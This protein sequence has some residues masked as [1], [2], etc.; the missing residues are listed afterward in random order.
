ML[1]AI[2]A[3]ERIRREMK[4]NERA[5]RRA[6]VDSIVATLHDEFNAQKPSLQALSLKGDYGV[7]VPFEK[8]QSKLSIHG[9]RR[10]SDACTTA[11]GI[12]VNLGS[13]IS[14]A[15]LLLVVNPRVDEG[16]VD[17]SMTIEYTRAYP[18]K[19]S[20]E[21]R[22]GLDTPIGVVF[23]DFLRHLVQHVVCP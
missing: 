7:A 6:L 13:Q 3:E 20:V 22:Y 9:G 4:D 11:F 15:S 10:G 8:A 12:K 23:E 14:P 18:H 5:S 21:V 17:G 1:E 16:D 2:L 19:S